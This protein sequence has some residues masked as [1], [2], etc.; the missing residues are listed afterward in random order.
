MPTPG[1]ILFINPNASVRVTEAIAATVAPFAPM[2]PGGL[3]T[4]RLEDGPQTISTDLHVAE[5]AVSLARRVETLPD[6]AAFVI[7]C[8][9]DPGLQAM[10]SLTDRPV[11]GLQQAGVMTALARADRFGIVAL[12]PA[13]IARQRLS[14]RQAGTLDRCV[15]WAH[16]DGASAEDI[17]HNPASLAQSKSAAGD[18]VARGA[19]AVV[20]GCAG[21]SPRRRQ[22]EQAIGVTVIDP[23]AAAAAM[24]VAALL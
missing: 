20:L 12:G 17:G 2:S 5:A 13:S 4:I 7:A 11:I 16:M 21:F 8:F 14:L 10:R 22:L 23:V 15:G 19:E 3:E 9:S 24:A 1:P 6:A 18:L